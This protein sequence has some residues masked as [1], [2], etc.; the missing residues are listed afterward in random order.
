M[1]V[2]NCLDLLED[3][4]DSYSHGELLHVYIKELLNRNNL[5]IEDLAA[6]AIS[7]GPGSYTG[8]R[9]G[10]ASAK[11]LC[12][13]Q[14]I[15]LISI[16]TLRALS[17]QVPQN[18]T[19]IPMM[20]ARRMEVYSAVYTNG[21]LKEKVAATILEEDSFQRYLKSGDATVLGTG[22]AKFQE[23]TA[24]RSNEYVSSVPTAL[25]MCN[26]AIQAYKKSDTVEDIAYFE[27]FYLK[28][29]KSN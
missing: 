14:D 5:T 6:V 22:A 26:L 15:P 24:D 20:D 9:I 27:P 4:S 13:A 21:E 23:L 25:T 28:E 7:K 12:F 29:F 3:K 1:N 18:K 16:D 8:L 19:V 11:G 10:V 17:L 2:K